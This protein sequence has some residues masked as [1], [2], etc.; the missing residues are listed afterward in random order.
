MLSRQGWAQVGDHLGLSDRELN[1]AILMFEGH[2]RTQIARRLGCAPGTIRVY[3]DRLF[4]K[5]NVADR[6]DMALRVIRV[7][8]A[9]G[10]LREN[11]TVSH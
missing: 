5:L 6:L 3:I 2:A 9:L 11:V 4:A 1:V 8:V 10:A 7:A